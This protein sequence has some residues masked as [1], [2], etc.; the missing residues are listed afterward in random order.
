[1]NRA[2]GVEVRY[3]YIVGEKIENIPTFLV[4]LKLGLLPQG[5]KKRMKYLYVLF[6]A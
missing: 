4:W 5:D 6:W 3:C 1:M 2:C